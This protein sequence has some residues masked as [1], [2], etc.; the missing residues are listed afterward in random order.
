MRPDGI[1]FCDSC[2]QDIS[3]IESLISSFTSGGNMPA[4]LEKIIENYVYMF[5]SR[6]GK[7]YH[8]SFGRRLFFG[9]CRLTYTVQCHKDSSRLRD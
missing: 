9:I 4:K 8:R 6:H 3:T 5:F 7:K 2:G 1:F